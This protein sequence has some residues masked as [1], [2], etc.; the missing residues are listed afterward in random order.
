MVEHVFL[1]F[2]VTVELKRD[3][4]AN[5]TSSGTPKTLDYSLSIPMHVN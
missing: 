4:F 1:H 5:P 2:P 3:A